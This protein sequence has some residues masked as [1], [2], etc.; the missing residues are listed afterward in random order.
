MTLTDRQI[1]EAKIEDKQYKLYDRE[2]LYLL[3]KPSGSKLW[4]FKYSFAGKE[5]LLAL[6]RYPEISLATARERQFE[7]RKQIARG[8]NPADSKRENKKQAVYQVENTFETIARQWHDTNSP[9]WKPTHAGMILRRIENHLFPVIG[10]RPINSL[11]PLDI[12]SLLKKIE[13]KNKFETVHRLLN[14]TQNVF[15]F[16]VIIGIIETNPAR[17]L[18]AAIKPKQTE[19]YPS[20]KDDQIKPFLNEID[21]VNTCVQYKLAVKLQMATFLRTSE[22]RKSKWVN[23]DFDKREWIVPAELM[24]MKHDHMVPLSDYTISLLKSLWQITGYSEYILPNRQNKKHPYMSENTINYVIRKTESFKELVGHGF[25]SLASTT[26]N[27][28]G[29]NRDAIERQLA[30]KEPNKVRAAYNF[31]EYL[32][33]RREMMQWWGDFIN[34]TYNTD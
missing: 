3:V 14:Y 17:E 20:I 26:L 33:E 16:A 4:R 1:R 27:E 2:G 11:K 30:H 8:I 15:R 34:N 28:H 6:D 24:K 12:L 18:G 7:A 21:Q 9:K 5:C 23:I 19:H 32:P 10:K 13:A 29:F 22:L 31:A 25:R